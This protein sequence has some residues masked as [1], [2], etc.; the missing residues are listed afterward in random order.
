MRLAPRDGKGS[1]LAILCHGPRKSR[2]RWETGDEVGRW[3]DPERLPCCICT[4]KQQLESRREVNSEFS[5]RFAKEMDS[6]PRAWALCLVR[7]LLC[8]LQ[9]ARGR[10]TEVFSC[11]DAGLH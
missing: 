5:A 8:R 6:C 2:M 4:G 7:P 9:C 3:V 10:Q 1:V 11:V